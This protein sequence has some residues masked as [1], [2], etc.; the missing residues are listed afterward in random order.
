MNSIIPPTD[1]EASFWSLIHIVPRKTQSLL[2]F[3]PHLRR[4]NWVMPSITVNAEHQSFPD[5]L[6]VEELL[7]ALGK[8]PR[9]LAVEVNRSVVP[10]TEHKNYLLGNGDQVEI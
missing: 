9:K 10:R 4:K 3:F 8:D 2:Q 1:H 7:R 6:S 5:P